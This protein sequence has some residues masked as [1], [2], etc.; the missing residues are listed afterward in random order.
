MTKDQ[1]VKQ[2]EEHFMESTSQ[3]I[4][5]ILNNII[6]PA[7]TKPFEFI[8]KLEEQILL[9]KLTPEEAAAIMLNYGAT[10]ADIKPDKLK[11]T[12][13]KLVQKHHPDKTG[14]DHSILARINAAYDV[15]KTT[16]YTPQSSKGQ[17]EEPRRQKRSE[18]NDGVPPWQTD[19]RSTYNTIR[20]ES[21]VD[22]NFIKKTMWELS[23]HSTEEYTI[24]GFDGT[25]F[26]NTITVYGNENIFKT[27]A[28]AMVEWQT[29]GGNPYPITAV[30]VQKD[31]QP[32]IIKLIWMDGKN[33][34][35]PVPLEHE[36][37]NMNPANDLRF[38]NS[39]P[40]TLEQIKSGQD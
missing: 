29:H 30:F 13:I 12:W 16:P 8:Q 34:I 37:P 23:N 35:P 40:K 38:M 21:Y 39:L 19:K 17:Q 2:C 7:A 36:S 25:F 28:R 33:I 32:D 22:A 26:R 6:D 15:L 18:Y 24:Y 11:S 27:M 14:G 20:V 5:K 31:N 3:H 9:E 4:R 10:D 1:Y